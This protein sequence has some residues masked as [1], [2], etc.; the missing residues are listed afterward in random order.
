M[1]GKRG[2]EPPA[3]ASRRQC[4][5][6][7]S[8]SPTESARHPG[9]GERLAGGA[10]IPRSRRAC[11]RVGARSSLPAACVE[12]RV[13]A[14]E[15]LAWRAVARTIDFRLLDPL[16]VAKRDDV[17]TAFR[18]QGI[19]RRATLFADRKSVGSGKSVEGR[20]VRGGRRILKKN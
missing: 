5:T 16:P 14:G 17:D 2:F 13:D 18:Q 4:S 8:Y 1:V 11:K 19:E 7:L 20:V 15:F 6:R 9:R 10:P 12:Q 3:P